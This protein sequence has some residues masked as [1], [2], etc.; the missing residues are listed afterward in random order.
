MIAPVTEAVPPLGLARYG[1]LF[2]VPHVRRLVLC[3]LLARLPM[4]M[5]GLA[6]LLLVRENGGSYASAGAVSGGY[7][8]ATAVGAPISGRLVDRRGQAQILLRR[9]VIFPALLGGVCVLALLDA[10]FALVGACAA[11]AGLLMPPVGASLRALWPRLFADGELRAAAYALEASLQEITFVVGPLLVAV[12]T[13]AV[14]PVL[15]LGVAAAAGGIGTTLIALAEPVRAWRPEEGHSGSILGALQS[16]GVVAIVGLSACLGFGFG[17]TEV[18]FPAFAEGHGGAELGSIPLSLFAAGSLVG[19][20]V[21]GARVTMTPLRL[22]RLST[23]L[24]VLG[25]ALPILGWSLP[26]MAVLAFL[27][28]LPIAPL[29]MSAYGLI[30][31]VAARGTAAEAFAWITTAVFAGFSVGMPLGGVLID[32]FGVKASFGLGAAAVSLGALLVALG[33][34]LDEG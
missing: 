7:F 34:G 10:P 20:L 15:A 18:G 2:R 12:L 23:P 31:A 29:V 27:A 22:L 9:A 16:R 25:L 32:A 28:G 33:P 14:S 30:D 24:L 1:A 11:G 4:G 5:I 6:L 3:G 17:A 21:A 26:S 8:V 19:G 13:A